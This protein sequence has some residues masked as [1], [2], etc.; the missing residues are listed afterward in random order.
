MKVGGGQERDPSHGRG[1]GQLRV[2]STEIGLRKGLGVGERDGMTSI[3]KARDQGNGT[4]IGEIGVMSTEEADTGTTDIERTITTETDIAMRGIKT[5]DTMVVRIATTG[6]SI[7]AIEMSG[8]ITARVIAPG[9]AFAQGRLIGPTLIDSGSDI[10]TLV[11]RRVLRVRD[12][13]LHKVGRLRDQ[14]PLLS[15][16]IVDHSVAHRGILHNLPNELVSHLLRLLHHLH[17][18]LVPVNE[19]VLAHAPPPH[20]SSSSNLLSHPSSAA[21][22]LLPTT[23]APG[24]PQN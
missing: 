16:I 9:L 5:I 18:S 24:Y 7:T 12:A 3:R 15:G 21:P 1:R 8:T 17:L 19:L 20:P 23:K 6:T 11:L 14:P 13:I 10:D 22:H 2:E 4:R